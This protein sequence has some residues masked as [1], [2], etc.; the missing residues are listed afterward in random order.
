MS[1]VIALGQNGNGL[2]TPIP[3]D[4]GKVLVSID[5]VALPEQYYPGGM[6]VSTRPP[7]ASG[8]FAVTTN[9]YF[10]SIDGM[11]TQN[12]PD[13]NL[14]AVP[15]LRNFVSTLGGDFYSTQA[16]PI[17]RY[18]IRALTAGNFA[19]G[20]A[21]SDYGADGKSEMQFLVNITAFNA[22]S[23]LTLKLYALMAS[24]ASHQIFSWRLRWQ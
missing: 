6:P 22:A 17:S 12:Y 13:D 21:H 24:G 11:T 5:G 14:Y 15:V 20:T 4:S 18:V 10:P 19:P 1:K 3:I 23:V 8:K 7:S 9:S 16:Y 2:L